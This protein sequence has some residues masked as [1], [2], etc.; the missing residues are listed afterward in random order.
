LG[1]YR[2]VACEG[3]LAALRPQEKLSDLGC[4][5]FRQLFQNGDGRILQTA[6][7]AADVSPVN[8]RIDRKSLLREALPHPQ[9]TKI[10]RHQRPGKAWERDLSFPGSAQGF[11]RLF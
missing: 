1:A 5:C 3:W 9:P 2:R 8:L 6:L 7:D 4:K 10:S 11:T